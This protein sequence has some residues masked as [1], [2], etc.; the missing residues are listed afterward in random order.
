MEIKNNINFNNFFFYYLVLI[1]FSSI[2]FMSKTYQLNVN[3]SMSEW[4]INYQGGFGRRGL[5]GEL[6]TQ[7][8]LIFDYPIRK[9]ILYFLY[10]IFISYYLLIYLFFR[11]IKTNYIIIISLL[12]PLFILSPL[13]ELEALGRKDILI[14]LFFLFY[15]N[16]YNRLNLFGLSLILLLFYTILL[17]THEV[18]IFYLPFFYLLLTFKIE[19]L[20]IYKIITLIFIALIFFFIIYIL[21]NSAHSPEAIKIMC[22]RMKNILNDKCGMGAYVLN[23]SLKHNIAELGGLNY[24]HLIRNFSIFILGYSALIILIQSSKFNESKNNILNKFFNLKLL[25]FLTFLPTLIPFTIAVDWGRW[26]NLSYT[27]LIL[28]YFFCIKNEKIFL[29]ENSKIINYLTKRFFKNKTNFFI[30]VFILC[31]TWNPKAV[32]H[33]DIGSIPIYR[34]LNKIITH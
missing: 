21:S 10:V 34:M 1:C 30:I 14:P 23:R 3:N 8:S 2:F 27:M 31:F 33:E 19:K 5:L 6:F 32:Y 4:L 13:A 12:S 20:T 11:N 18:S 15:C 24:I 22:E 26:F 25:I 7:L 16:L 29:N 28:F 17:L 9:I